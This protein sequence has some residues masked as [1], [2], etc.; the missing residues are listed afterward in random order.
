MERKGPRISQYPVGPERPIFENVARRL[1]EYEIFTFNGHLRVNKNIQEYNRVHEYEK[2]HQL[3]EKHRS[4]D[5]LHEHGY[6]EYKPNY[7]TRDQ[8]EEMK[9]F[10]Q[11]RR[12]TN[13]ELI[14]IGGPENSIHEHDYKEY[15]SSP[16]DLSRPVHDTFSSKNDS[17]MDKK[18]HEYQIKS[19]LLSE[20]NFHPFKK[21]NNFGDVEKED[22]QEE[23][24]MSF[25]KRCKLSSMLP[26]IQP[27]WRPQEKESPPPDYSSLSNARPRPLNQKKNLSVSFDAEEDN[28]KW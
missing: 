26:I 4:Y 9:S 24:D 22:S 25:L 21:I 14:P 16:Y 3:Y 23:N 7:I 2:V 15:K 17:Y 10:K 13:V 27:K 1:P 6:K 20:D 19:Y 12:N 8:H 28:F 5:N 11:P 18:L